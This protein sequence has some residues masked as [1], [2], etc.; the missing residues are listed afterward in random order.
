MDFIIHCTEVLDFFSPKS[1]SQVFETPGMDLEHLKLLV[2]AC[3]VIDTFSRVF[4]R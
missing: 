3:K 4:P 2:R 1:N